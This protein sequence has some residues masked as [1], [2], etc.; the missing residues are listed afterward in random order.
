VVL[1]SNWK[2][3]LCPREENVGPLWPT[4]FI[5]ILRVMLIKSSYSDNITE[6]AYI[7]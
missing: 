5:L 3:T 7:I 2:T 1:E 4:P 6:H